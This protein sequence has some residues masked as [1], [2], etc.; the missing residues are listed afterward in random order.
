MGT[1]VNNLVNCARDWGQKFHPETNA[2]QGLIKRTVAPRIAMVGAA[3]VNGEKV[4]ENIFRGAV[5]TVSF[6][7]KL[8]IKPISWIS[9][10]EAVKNFENKFSGVSDLLKTVARIVKHAIGVFAATA[11]VIIPRAA[12][13]LHDKLGL[14]VDKRAAALLEE[15]KNVPTAPCCAPVAV[16]TETVVVPAEKAPV[17]ETTVV[18]AIENAEAAALE[19]V[20]EAV[21]E[22]AVANEIVDDIAVAEQQAKLEESES[23]SFDLSEDDLLSESAEAVAET[24]PQYVLNKAKVLADKTGITSLFNTVNAKLD[25]VLNS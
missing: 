23:Y 20:N 5:Q 15:T 17:A 21:A 12:I 8:P 13:Y 16:A 14:S 11:G 25:Q 4:I 18:A 9:G 6:G 10:S 7:L 22:E 1:T 3:V 24:T 19:A 2:A